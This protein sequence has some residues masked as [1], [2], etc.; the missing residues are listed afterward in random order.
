MP[1]VKRKRKVRLGEWRQHDLAMAEFMIGRDVGY[2][3]G[4]NFSARC[5]ATGVGIAPTG[6]EISVEQA[7]DAFLALRAKQVGSG[8]ASATIV[9]GVGVW[10]G[11]Q[12]QSVVAQILH[13]P[14]IGAEKTR[15]GF[16]KNMVSM[17]QQ[18][19]CAL[20]QKEVLLRLWQPRNR[21]QV[22]R[23]KPQGSVPRGVKGWRRD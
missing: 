14:G 1:K 7:R 11:G 6:S 12:E 23:C 3:L 13:M 9:S 16:K 18:V 20:S 21:P 15:A 5:P 2:P 19:A 8:A 22:F 10:Q 4:T 17:C